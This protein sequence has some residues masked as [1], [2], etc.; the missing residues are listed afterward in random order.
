M[1]FAGRDDK[2][3]PQERPEM[4]PGLGDFSDLLGNSKVERFV[5]H[6]GKERIAHALPDP[7]LR[8]GA[9]CPETSHRAGH[10]G[11]AHRRPDTEGH[12]SLGAAAQGRQVFLDLAQLA[13]NDAGT[14]NEGAACGGERHAARGPRQELGLELPLEFREALAHGGLRYAD[15]SRRRPQAAGLAHRDEVPDLI[16]AHWL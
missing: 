7:H 4:N 16:Q 5:A 11:Q 3:Q 12:R 15:A 1:T 13:L 6:Q 10:Q 2:L 14:G 8:P 9:L